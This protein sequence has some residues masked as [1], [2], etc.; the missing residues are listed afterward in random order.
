MPWCSAFSDFSPYAFLFSGDPRVFVSRMLGCLVAWLAGCLAAWL[1]GCLAARRCCY[2]CCCCCCSP[3]VCIALL[4]SLGAPAATAPAP[5][6]TA[7][8]FGKLQGPI[9]LGSFASG[10]QQVREQAPMVL[11]GISK[12]SCTKTRKCGERQLAPSPKPFHSH[13][14]Y[15]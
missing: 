7:L 1:P 6:T 12:E 2:C 15:H 5:A 3:T 13:R 4:A 11:T 10:I 8:T 14:H 9:L